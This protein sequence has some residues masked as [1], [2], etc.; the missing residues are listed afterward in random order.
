MLRNCVN[1]FFLSRLEEPAVRSSEEFGSFSGRRPMTA[2]R[3]AES[4]GGVL[5]K[6]AI[7]L[8][9]WE[10]FGLWLASYQLLSA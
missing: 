4:G 2:T 10:F 8:D 3:A 9:W 5:T 7:S 6:P 1:M